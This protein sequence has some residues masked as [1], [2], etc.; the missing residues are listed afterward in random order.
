MKNWKM[1]YKL[2]F[3]FGIITIL[4]CI[5]GYMADVSLSTSSR[6]IK[7]MA[8]AYLP[9][10]DAASNLLDDVRVVSY[11]IR[12]FDIYGNASDYNTAEKRL[13][14]MPPEFERL[15]ITARAHPDLPFIS[16]ALH[17]YPRFYTAYKEGCAASARHLTVIKEKNEHMM[18]AADTAEGIMNDLEKSILENRDKFFAEGDMEALM[19]SAHRLQA[20][21]QAQLLYKDFRRQY[22]NARRTYD[23]SAKP[24]LM[25]A[26]RDALGF[27]EDL[28]RS[29]T[30]AG[31]RERSG[32]AITFLKT[33][34]E[35]MEKLLQTWEA[36]D[37]SAKER[38]QAAGQ[39]VQLLERLNIA[40]NEGQATYAHSTVES[41]GANMLRMTIITI[42]SVV[43]AVAMWIFTTR[44]ITIPLRRGMAFAEHVA[45]GNLDDKL[46]VHSRDELGKLADALRTMVEA[47]K[48]RIAEAAAQTEEARV[49]SRQASKA[50][51]AAKAAQAAAE[52]AR[53]EG[54]LAA[55][56]QLEN[57]VE[58]VSTASGQLSLQ[59][60]DSERGAVTTAE[61]MDETATAMEEMNATVLAVARSAGDAAKVSSEARGKAEEGAVVVRDVVTCMSEV[62][63]Q[64]AQLK[65]D[66]GQLGQQAEA[67]GAIMN[68]ISDIAD[69]T[70]LLA[71]NA[72]IEAARA[73]DAGRGFAVVADEVRKLAEKTMQATVEVGSAIRGVQDSAEKNMSGVDLSSR[74]IIKATGLVQQA[75]ASLQEIV[76][77]VE[78]SADQVRTIATAAEQQSLTSEEINRSLGSVNSASSETA[79]AM[80]DAAKAVVEL[81]NQSQNLAKIIEEMKKV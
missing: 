67:I 44:V 68:V 75:G 22:A 63:R 31:E 32:K 16:E 15:Q 77:L 70:N 30:M 7:K 36:L 50:M 35:D 1:A 62:E 40:A 41:V 76:Q 47:L 18:A 79:R 5:T 59:V 52:N 9:A 19:N 71:L 28:Q 42:V 49:Q 4:V 51:E 10:S 29:T 23:V 33:Y 61:R 12:L 72:A 43:L 57:I 24:A 65:E 64:A 6:S 13:A 80:A 69:Q 17:D 66:M 81:S 60:R 38:E 48:G 54:M 21:Q 27:L 26:G 11:H 78:N 25:K 2:G 58:V 55:A 46:E 3:G 8:T 56:E 53:R 45:Q 37:L 20:L 34:M 73:G 74:S 14:D 39:L